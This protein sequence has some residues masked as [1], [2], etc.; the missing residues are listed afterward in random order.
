MTNERAGCEQERP[1]IAAFLLVEMLACG[2]YAEAPGLR[3]RVGIEQ[4]PY[5]RALK[6]RVNVDDLTAFWNLYYVVRLIDQRVFPDDSHGAPFPFDTYNCERWQDSN[7]RPSVSSAT[8]DLPD[9]L[10]ICA[11]PFIDL[12]PF[13]LRDSL[14][15]NPPAVIP[16]YLAVLS[17]AHV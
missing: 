16:E 13:Y 5:R 11:T 1:E 14:D 15:L 8:A 7:L 2:C 17:D 10:T 4:H 9:A 3:G 12:L 6:L